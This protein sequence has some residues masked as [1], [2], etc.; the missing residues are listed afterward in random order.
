MTGPAWNES[1]GV[2]SERFIVENSDSELSDEFVDFNEIDDEF[3]MIE[4]QP[5]QTFKEKLASWGVDCRISHIH[6]NK[7]LSILKSH[8]S[9]SDLPVDVRTLFKTPRK[10]TL[11]HM[12]PGEYFNFFYKLKF[13]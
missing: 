11:I 2:D 8:P 3:L 5:A 13:L 1:E 10:V 4:Q 7:L 6:V 9:H 12:H